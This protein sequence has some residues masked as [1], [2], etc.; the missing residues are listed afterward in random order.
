MRSPEHRASSA[1]RL[2][3]LKAREGE[4][5]QARELVSDSL[6]SSPDDLRAQEEQV[7]ILSATG[8]TSEAAEQAKKLLQ[9]FPLSAFL[10]E[11]AGDPDIPHLGSD[12]YRVLNIAA[13]Y[14][15]LGLYR[16]ALEVL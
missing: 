12:P 13:Q 3:E 7:A 2:A 1:L 16:K 4:L 15:R 10:R 8:E 11:V 9:R 14:A 6:K 5:A